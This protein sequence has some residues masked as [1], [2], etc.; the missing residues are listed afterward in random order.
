ML[1]VCA[2]AC[3]TGASECTNCAAGKYS[4]ATAATST[5]TCLDCA[6]GSYSGAQGVLPCSR[7]LSEYLYTYTYICIH[8]Y[9]HARARTH[10]HVYICMYMYM[11]T[12]THTHT[13]THTYIYIYILTYMYARARAYVIRETQSLMCVS[14]GFEECSDKCAHV[15]YLK[16]RCLCV[17]RNPKSVEITTYLVGRPFS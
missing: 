7:T 16:P 1:A 10:T 6:A 15:L 17:R 13:H 9:M 5:D 12:H 4:T 2:C 3:T 8:T 14:I 11:Y